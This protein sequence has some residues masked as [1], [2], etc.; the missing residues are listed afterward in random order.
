MA[1]SSVSVDL[2]WKFGPVRRSVITSSPSVYFVRSNFIPKFT[3]TFPTCS[4]LSNNKTPFLPYKSIINSKFIINSSSNTCSPVC[5]VLDYD[6]HH[7]TYYNLRRML[8]SS[9]LL[10]AVMLMSLFCTQHPAFAA[11]YGRMGSSSRSSS[12]SSSSKPS[13]SSYSSCRSS[14]SSRPSSSC[15]SLSYTTDIQYRNYDD[16]DYFYNTRCSG[17]TCYKGKRKI[18]TN[19]NCFKQKGSEPSSSDVNNVINLSTSKCICKCHSPCK[20]TCHSAT[21]PKPVGVI[22]CIFFVLAVIGEENRQ[23]SISDDTNEDN[24]QE[25]DCKIEVPDIRRG[26]VLMVQVWYILLDN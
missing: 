9:L 13:R 1:I 14:T 10:L 16:I 18:C 21:I 17:C 11:S 2:T 3:C 20:C 12:S 26:S 15:S 6:I 19:C 8:A 25:P 7:P 22:M 5:N 24:V 4:I 23:N